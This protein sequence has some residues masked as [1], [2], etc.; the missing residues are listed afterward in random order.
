MATDKASD[1]DITIIGGG[2][3]GLAAALSLAGKNCSVHILEA[4]DPQQLFH[5]RHPSFDDRT[6]VVNPASRLFWQGLGLWSELV[7][8]STA[9]N[10]VHVSQKG[11]FGSVVFDRDE[12]QV[13]H[14]AHV[15]EA[16]VLGQSLWQHVSKHPHITLSAPAELIRFSSGEADVLIQY[17]MDSSEQSHRSRLM[18]AADGARSF[19][20][21]KLSLAT[22]TKNYQ[23]TAII[24]NVVTALP[25]QHCAYERL[26]ATGPMALLPFHDRLGL[27]WTLPEQ[28]AKAMLQADDA[29]FTAA[30]QQAMG[31]R[32]GRIN[33]VGKRTS[34]PLYRIT[35]PQQY[36]QRVLLM[37]NAAHTVS[38]V[39]AQGLNLGVRGIQ[40]LTNILAN[41]LKNN[42]DIGSDSVLAAYQQQSWPD[43]QTILQYTDDLMTWFKL[44]QPIINS[45]RSLGL[46]AIDS[47]T[48][49]KRQFYQ[50]AGGLSELS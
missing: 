31:F 15:L 19:V 3:V 7:P 46:L 39:S 25:H 41:V 12:L 50:L 2:L 44:D 21:Q 24:A 30:L 14:L 38:P 1:Y 16:K 28:Q 27:V 37:G 48:G 32:L 34:Y 47:L 20:R 45:C 22:V 18:L 35:V 42:G 8:H 33:R 40:R 17:K 26:T 5:S 11:Q 6:L 49:L 4:G 43:Q 10:Q 13:A 29:D 36:K 9:V 23:R